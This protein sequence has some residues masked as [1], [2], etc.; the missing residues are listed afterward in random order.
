MLSAADGRAQVLA[1][2]EEAIGRSGQAITRQLIAIAALERN[3]QDARHA[4]ELLRV[5]EDH[6]TAAHTTRERLLDG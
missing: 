3:G 4:H 1:K 2:V 5:A 6:R